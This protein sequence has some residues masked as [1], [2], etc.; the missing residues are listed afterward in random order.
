LQELEKIAP[1]QKGII[2]QA[3]KDVVQG[4]VDDGLVESE[5]IGTSIYYWSYPG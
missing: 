1:K 3:V 2:A 4:L 5:R